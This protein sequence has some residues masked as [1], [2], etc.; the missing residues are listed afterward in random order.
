MYGIFYDSYKEFVEKMQTRKI[1]LF[2]AGKRCLEIMQDYYR[3]PFEEIAF[4]CD[5]DQ[6]KWGDMLYSIPICSP[7]MLLES[8]DDYVVLIAVYDDYSLKRIMQQLSGM[9]VP[10]FYTAAILMFANMIERYDSDGNRKYHEFNTYKVIEANMDNICKVRGML[11]DEKS[12]RLYDCFI[13][14]VKYNVKDYMDITDDLYEHYFSDGIFKYSDG[15]V[16]VDGGAFDGD[17]TVWFSTM[18]HQQGI[19]LKKSYCFEPDT[20]NFGKTCRNLESHFGIRAKLNKS[21]GE[22]ECDRFKVFKAG[23][24][25]QNCGIGFC[26]YGAHSSRVTKEKKVDSSVS[27]VRLDDVLNN[28]KVTFIKY[29]L[30]GADVPAIR[31][32]EQIIKQYRP[33]LA[34]SIY[35]NIDD[36]WVIPLLIKAYVPEYKLFVRHH[37]TYLW[38]KILYAAVEEDLL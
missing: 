15:E 10:H 3:Y 25:D 32:A 19:K 1:V 8:P 6:E 16:L 34:L 2:C 17:D 33:K 18:L 31:G 27:A 9:K 22:A 28:E 12:V 35:H 37:T 4:I 30:E 24:F 23:L 20:S 29:D 13:E 26:E 21:K 11:E 38:D 7:E 14:K 5:N 36:L